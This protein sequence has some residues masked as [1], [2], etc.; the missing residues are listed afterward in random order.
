MNAQ[1]ILSWYSGKSLEGASLAL[2]LLEKSEGAGYWLPGASRKVRSLL[3]KQNI[4]A[5]QAKVIKVALPTSLQPLMYEMTYGNFQNSLRVLDKIE[6]AAQ[7]RLSDPEASAMRA[8]RG[9]AKDFAPI[10]KLVALLDSR[11][12][13]PTIVCKTLSPSVVANL[14]G[15]LGM[16]LAS[17][18]IPPMKGEWVDVTRPIKGDRYNR[19]ETVK[20]WHVEIIWPDG[21]RHLRSRFA[22]GSNAGNM[23]CEACGHAIRDPYNWLPLVAREADGIPSSLWVGRDCARKLLECEVDSG[24]AIYSGRAVAP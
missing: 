20:V 16:S 5:M 11:R 9:W 1:A 13:K 15:K 22:H 2:D 4:A 19:T 8:F 14:S 3:S 7:S 12:P 6:V 18:G 10:A 17:I 24:E 23:Q 21:T